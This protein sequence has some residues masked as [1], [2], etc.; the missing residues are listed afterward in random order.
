[1]DVDADTNPTN[2]RKLIVIG[3]DCAPPRFVFHEWREEMPTLSKLMSNGLWGDLESSI[4]PITVPAWTSMLS[5]TNPGRLGFTGFRNRKKGT[6]NEKWIANSTAI[7][8]KRVWDILGERGKKVTLV[9]VP[10]TYPPNAVNGVM[11]SSFLTPDTETTE[12]TYPPELKQ[13]IKELMGGTYNVD[14]PNF[15]TDDK[16]PLLAQIYNMTEQRFLLFDHLITTRPWDFAMMVVMG[17][18]RIHHGFWKYIDKK[19]PRFQPGHKLERSMLRYYKFIDH[20]IAKLLE[21][22]P[23]STAVMVVSDHGARADEGCISINDWLMRE[24]W[25]KLKEP[26]SKITQLKHAPIDWSQTKAWGWGGYYSRIFLN[27]K[28]REPEG[29]IEPEDFEKER[30]VLREAIMNIPDHEGRPLKHFILT[31]EEAFPGAEDVSHAPDLIVYL[32]D[33]GWRAT[34][35][36]G[37]ENI[38]QFESELGPDHAMHDRFGIYIHN[39]PNALIEGGKELQGLQLMDVA[40]TILNHFNIEIPSDWEGKVITKDR[41]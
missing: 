20:E 13:E 26:I 25:M 37:Y 1:M 21:K 24:G 39:D 28:G 18:D 33:L 34:Q 36:I 32:G 6:Y 27:V 38:H 31:P 14:V 11:V 2:D 35:S 22:V 23:K 4:P 40:P 19:H 29:I 30:E 9:G 8:V 5:S 17:T 15:R 7:K 16:L 41:N 3:L 12:Y 10:Q